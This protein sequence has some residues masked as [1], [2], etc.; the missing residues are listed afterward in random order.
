VERLDRLRW[1]PFHTRMVLELGTAWI[2][3]GLQTTISGSVTGVLQ[4]PATLGLSS[5]QIGLI[6][7]VYLV[8]EV[9]GALVFGRLSD[10]LERR[11]LVIWTLAG[12]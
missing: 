11:R 10:R 3:D 8:G 6:A 2:L 12:R 4:E 5:T 9:A 1:P 7:S